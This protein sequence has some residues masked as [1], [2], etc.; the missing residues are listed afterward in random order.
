[1]TAER[2]EGKKS[3][4]A[5]KPQKDFNLPY[6]KDTQQNRT[7]HLQIPSATEKKVEPRSTRIMQEQKKSFLAPTI[8]S[9]SKAYTSIQTTH[10]TSSSGD[11]YGVA[12]N[13]Y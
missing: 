7:K 8:T 3:K 4:S 9:R 2:H 1:M 11:P 5:A 10:T 13:S 6:A 12:A